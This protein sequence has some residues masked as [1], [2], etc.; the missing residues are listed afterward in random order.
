MNQIEFS[1][2]SVG[3][4]VL[5]IYKGVVVE[6]EIESIHDA[7]NCKRT[8]NLKVPNS[9]KLILRHMYAIYPLN[10]TRV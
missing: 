5:T 3:D 7:G 2:I 8:V 9:N 1:K 10:I 6:M 4:K